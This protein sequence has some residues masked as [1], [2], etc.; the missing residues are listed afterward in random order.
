MMQ[1]LS[2]NNKLYIQ[3]KDGGFVEIKNGKLELPKQDESY[4]YSDTPFLNLSPEEKTFS[5]KMGTKAWYRTQKAL[6]LIKPK[7]KKVRKGKRYV[8]KEIISC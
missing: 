7:Y 8:R 3:N 2:T 1:D 5:F 6:G 4:T